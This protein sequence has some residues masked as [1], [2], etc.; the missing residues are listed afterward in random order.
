[1]SKWHRVALI[2][3][4]A[5]GRS[6]LRH[7]ARDASENSA[8]AVTVLARRQPAATEDAPAG[9]RIV[10][11]LQDLLSARPDVVV[12]CAG[13]DAVT[14]LALPIVSAGCDL[15]MIST[16]ALVD[17]ALRESIVAAARSS[18]AQIHLP[19]GAIA[20]IDGLAAL[21][22]GGLDSVTY[23][24]IKPPRAWIG[25]PAESVV[26]L[27]AIDKQTVVFE[28]SAR[29]A[30]RMFPRN[31]NLAATVALAGIGLDA[32]RVRLVADPLTREN[33]GIVEANGAFG[34]MSVRFQGQSEADNPR[35]SAS[36]ALSLA[37]ALLNARQT[38][39]I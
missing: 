1:M 2:G 22:L 29:K 27:Q 13:H 12:E 20:G 38:V 10:T 26:N 17:D 21:R 8:L 15:M 30:A 19:A 32:T 34:S 28:G 31:A 18:G 4:G 16:G 3:L 9:T 37:R 36:T 25:S 35:S 23:T 11:T 24:S 5:I 14:E 33:C 39:V 7:L 6:L